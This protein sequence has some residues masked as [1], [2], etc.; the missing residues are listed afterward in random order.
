MDASG[1]NDGSRSQFWLMCRR[2]CVM[3]GSVDIAFFFIFYYLDSPILAWVNVVSVAMYAVAYHAL[4][5]RRNRFAVLLIWLEVSAHAALGTVLIGW[6]SGFH[7]YLLMFIPALFTGSRSVRGAGFSVLCLWLF[8]V[9]LSA[10]TRF[11]PIQPISEDALAWVHL[12]NLT[13]LFIMSSSL[14]LY[15]MSTV[16]KAHQVLR[17]MATTDPLTRLFNRR[18]MMELAARD[19]SNEGPHSPLVAFLLMDVDYSK[20]IN[21]RFGHDTGDRV[22]C[23]I[24]RIINNT[25]RENDYVGRWGGEEFLAVLPDSDSQQAVMVAERVRAAVAAHDWTQ[26]GLDT[27][28][29][30]SL[31]V[32]HYL[33]GEGF[34][35]SV[36]RADAALY[37]SK[38]N[39]RNR[40]ESA[41]ST[42]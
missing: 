34:S 41:D 11:A 35:E 22:L 33:P 5:R 18:H 13:V 38:A 20:Q 30:L 29:T 32:S 10:T 9:A 2:C 39:G 23:E 27:A 26:L 16:N 7:Y 36:A 6:G 40:V 12:F 28:V 17:R 14:S 42:P 21:D 4:K 31:G 19:I 8:Y 1:V 25:L 37:V 3:A 15:Y 24:S